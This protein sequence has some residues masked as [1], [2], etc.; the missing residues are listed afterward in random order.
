MVSFTAV[1][2]GQM[3][4]SMTI[5]LFVQTQRNVMVLK[6]DFP[7]AVRKSKRLINFVY[8]PLTFDFHFKIIFMIAVF[9]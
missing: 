7:P 1:V 3:T 8:L 9:F 4:L 5:E 6:N 2:D